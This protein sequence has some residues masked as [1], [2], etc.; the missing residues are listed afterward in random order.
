MSSNGQGVNNCSVCQTPFARSDRI[1]PT[2]G[3]ASTIA[4]ADG[5]SSTAFEGSGHSPQTSSSPF[6][7][8]DASA[9]AHAIQ[10]APATTSSPVP[11]A[12]AQPALNPSAG[13]SAQLSPSISTAAQQAG[14]RASHTSLG[15]LVRFQHLQGVIA[16][17]A[18]QSNQPIS[19]LPIFAGLAALGVLFFVKLKYLGGA[20]PISSVAP[21]MLV[22]FG[23][24]IIVLWSVL[25]SAS[26]GSQGLDI[27][28]FRLVTAEGD[29]HDCRLFGTID[30]GA[31]RAGDS[32]KI[33]GIVS[34]DHAI[35]VARVQNR[36]TGS[37][38]RPSAPIVYRLVQVCQVA[39]AFVVLLYFISIVT[40]AVVERAAL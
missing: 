2:C 37:V 25:S 12:P 21:A 20:F 39:I 34:R 23:L 27:T 30:T 17:P 38:V 31:L 24:G 32:I 26:A 6:G 14:P 10:P 3:S 15:R 35:R 19:V 13:Q 5:A 36:K 11:V 1:C 40:N 33:A 7:V 16:G 22:G 4:Q 29:T 9:P 18:N 8:P 28:S